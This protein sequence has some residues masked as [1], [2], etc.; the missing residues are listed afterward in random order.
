MEKDEK[1]AFGITM[2][3][4]GFLDYIV[5]A[6]ALVLFGG[7]GATVTEYLLPPHEKGGNGGEALAVAASELAVGDAKKFE[8]NGKAALVIHMPTGFFALSAV[9]THLGCIVGWDR[10]KKLIV[11]PC[12][13]GIFDYRGNIVSGPPPKPLQSFQVAI[14]NGNVMVSGGA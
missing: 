13:N 3:R 2:T 6:G 8:F 7:M 14:R 5:G 1:K 10:D 9:C 4:R 12:H 11:C